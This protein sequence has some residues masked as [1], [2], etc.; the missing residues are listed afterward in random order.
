[1]LGLSPCRRRDGAAG[2]RIRRFATE[3]PWS[4]VC[5]GTLGKS[6]EV[7]SFLL[8][9]PFVD[10]VGNEVV[11]SWRTFGGFIDDPNSSN[12]ELNTVFRIVPPTPIPTLSPVGM[13]TLILSL[14]LAFAYV[15]R[16]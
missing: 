15:R 12:N 1:M 14:L 8:Q 13:A 7:K 2:W 4:L 3:I 5:P 6:Y 10:R 16:R 9:D 11:V